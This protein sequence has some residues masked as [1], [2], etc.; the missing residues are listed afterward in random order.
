MKGVRSVVFDTTGSGY[1]KMRSK[2]QPSEQKI[3]SILSHLKV[4][5][6]KLKQVEL[7]R[8]T[9]KYEITVKGVS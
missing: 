4:K 7:P 9:S 3:N 5:V 6:K 1:L 2:A 8:K